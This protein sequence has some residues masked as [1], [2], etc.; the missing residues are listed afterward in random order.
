MIIKLQIY[1]QIPCEVTRKKNSQETQTY[2]QN[3]HRNREQ[4]KNT[5][6]EQQQGKEKDKGDKPWVHKSE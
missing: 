5:K 3:R 2:I 1:F 6:H 4:I